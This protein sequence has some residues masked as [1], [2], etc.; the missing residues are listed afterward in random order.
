M[1]IAIAL[2]ETLKYFRGARE[3]EKCDETKEF[4]S[5]NISMLESKLIMLFAGNEVTRIEDS[6]LNNRIVNALHGE[7]IYTFYQL[8]QYTRK[9][10]LDFPNIGEEYLEDIEKAMAKEGVKFAS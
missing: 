6:D 1:N 9:E 2:L 4:Y 8:T 7:G 5:D 10:V 3:V